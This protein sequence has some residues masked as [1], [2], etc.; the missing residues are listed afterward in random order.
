MTPNPTPRTPRRAPALAASLLL[1]ATPLGP[2]AFAFAETDAAPSYTVVG[3]V[4]E[5]AS[6]GRLSDADVDRFVS[7]W[8]AR[9]LDR[10]A[11]ARFVVGDDVHD[12]G[13]G[14]EPVET[15]RYLAL[16]LFDGMLRSVEGL[17]GFFSTGDFDRDQALFLRALD[18]LYGLAFDKPAYVA[19][20]RKTS[21]A[22]SRPLGEP[23]DADAE[24]PVAAFPGMKR[25]EIAAFH[26][27]DLA[28]SRAVPGRPAAV[29][30]PTPAIEPAPIEP[31]E[32]R[33]REGEPP[34]GGAGADAAPS[35][36][37]P[38]S[39]P[40]APLTVQPP[41]PTSLF[42]ELA[43]TPAGASYYWLCWSHAGGPPQCASPP[44]LLGITTGA[45]VDGNAATGVPLTGYDLTVGL[46]VSVDPEY[47]LGFASLLTITRYN[48]S[49]LANV[50]VVYEPALLDVRVAL[51]VDG[52]VA[53]FEPLMTVEAGLRNVAAAFD[54][55]VQAFV[56]SSLPNPTSDPL[57][58]TFA[59]AELESGNAVD[60]VGAAIRLDP[61]PQGFVSDVRIRK[62]ASLERFEGWVNASAP[63]E[64]GLA[65]EARS[66][67]SLHELEVT[68]DELPTAAHFL[69][70]RH[71]PTRG[72]RPP[73]PTIDY[74]ASAPVGRF[75]FEDKSTPDVGAPS[76]W[77]L[78][79]ADVTGVPTMVHLVLAGPSDVTY[80]ANA[81]VPAATVLA[82]AHDAGGLVR[83]VRVDVEDVPTQVRVRA[84]TS[85]VRIL[86]DANGVLGAVEIDVYD[87]LAA[88]SAQ[89]GLDTVPPTV[90]L[91]ADA[92]GAKF[93]ASAPVGSAWAR[94]QRGPT[95]APVLSGH[96]A[97]VV[98]HTSTSG[99]VAFALS[100][101]ISE[102]KR[103]ESGTSGGST[104]V[105]LVRAPLGEERP[106]PAPFR[107]RADVVKQDGF[108]VYAD[109]ILSQMP[110][111]IDVLAGEE[112]EIST[113]NS[114]D[115]TLYAHA[116]KLAAILDAANPPNLHGVSV[117]DGKVGGDIAHRIRAYLTGVPTYV[118]VEPE[119]TTFEMTGWRPTISTFVGDIDL[120]HLPG[121]HL[122]AYVWLSQVPRPQDV[123]LTA[124]TAPL[125]GGAPSAEIELALRSPMGPMWALVTWNDL[126]IIA[127]ASE[128]PKDVHVKYAVEDGETRMEWDASE[129]IE[130]AFAG[131]H[132]LTS[133]TL[134]QTVVAL[135]DIPASFE[136]VAGPSGNGPLVEYTADAST[137][138]V[139]VL[140]DD[141]LLDDPSLEMEDLEFR[142][143][144]LGKLVRTSLDDESVRIESTP[145]T[146]YLYARTTL[147]LH[148][149]QDDSNT[150]AC[151]L[152]FLWVHTWLV[153]D[154]DITS[155][156][157][158]LTITDLEDLRF[159]W[160][161][162]Q[163]VTGE[164]S[165]FAIHLPPIAFEFGMDAG[166]AVFVAWIFPVFIG[167]IVVPHFFDASTTVR[168]HRY[169][170]HAGPTTSFACTDRMI[171]P[172]PHGW[173][174]HGTMIPKSAEE[175]GAWFITA[176]PY[177]NDRPLGTELV[178]VLT[179]FM[180]D[181][182]QA[183]STQC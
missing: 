22:E 161:V 34:G 10:E 153:L 182:S 117:R 15:K 169:T 176:M 139:V 171:D 89:G 118:R 53:G 90:R 29:P 121:G 73:P 129:P 126:E 114:F 122:D 113:S 105:Q 79:A 44:S 132:Y 141:T 3:T 112:F 94:V 55:D 83:S 57:A 144:N 173:G 33:E 19:N 20:L 47:P 135:E 64:A 17:E 97:S 71:F 62:T 123:Y 124:S 128:V 7:L 26:E 145:A 68:I 43:S 27:N 178:D 100:L 109:G 152:A 149:H 50:W 39:R 49:L 69:S 84:L 127:Y 65:V 99:V 136:L 21:S 150:W 98:H 28:R 78:A 137:L 166:I 86:Y 147:G 25:S 96:H 131:F 77:S 107:V 162:T 11:M 37:P 95:A 51:G 146:P 1:L 138:D 2:A 59:Y 41:D 56:E 31:V 58:I 60:P 52:S 103:F 42:D 148:V 140:V 16:Q 72:E 143:V 66:G 159:A 160:G 54:G 48:P 75:T 23:V 168:F 120:R 172:H 163:K 88:F 12:D 80:E 82:Q 125:A 40:L 142:I 61:Y 35:P 133:P 45:N 70:Q 9:Y 4:W 154:L 174:D 134:F 13:Y 167:G 93:E 156:D 5:K 92:D 116:G 8:T 85:P 91:E 183:L 67:A 170:D 115:L 38:A 164:Y 18:A 101:R 74:D 180:T 102:V 110:W 119:T 130:K 81:P 87:R 6:Q 106:V 46:S 155:A 63:A 177:L 165:T 36:A 151:C 24:G 111:Q 157:I 30:G 158:R 14:D 32:E 108:R 76:V 179:Q 181:G 175:G 104:T